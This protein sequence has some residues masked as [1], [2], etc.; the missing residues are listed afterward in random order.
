[1]SKTIFIPVF[2][3]FVSRNILNTGVLDEL[4]S[5][6]AKVV[7]FVPTP[8]IDFY[9]SEYE[10]ERVI[11][12]AFDT[13]KFIDKKERFFKNLAELLIDSNVIRFRMVKKY[14]NSRKLLSYLYHRSIIGLFGRSSLVKKL[15]R[16]MDLNLNGKDAFEKYFEQYKP[17]V[18]FAT[19][20]FGQGDVMLL[21]SALKRGVRSVGM[22][23]SWDNNTTK[24]LMRVVPNLLIVQNEIIKDE[25][26]K[27]QKVPASILHVVGIAHYDYYMEYKPIG[28]EEYF[29]KIGLNPS[30]RLV[31]FSPAGDKFISTDW[32]ICEILKRAYS[33]GKLP[34]DVV[35][36]VRVHPTNPVSFKD[37][38]PNEHFLI[39]NPGVKFE[40]MADKKK[41]LDKEGLY[42]LLN[43]LAH[44]DVVINVLSS[45]VI[46]AAVFDKPIITIGFEGWEKR[47]SFGNSVK[48]Y[49]MDENMA[50][51]LAIEGTPVV[52]SGRELIE[53]INIYLKHPE[54][55]RAG[56]AK[57][58]EKQCWKLDGKAKLR[59]AEIIMNNS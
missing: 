23:A 32:Q 47:V 19:D 24:G 25:S 39:E 12:E 34:D 17:D 49:H 46:D 48:R 44:V 8:K 30:K 55:D 5:R 56:R 1:M 29:H 36:L 16:R 45:I 41:E 43:T 26:M 18:I 58:V 20:V 52:K 37:F 7:L 22:V 35:I 50:K 51:L 33:E 4:L 13:D 9:K 27:I 14:Q 54:I 42:H 40:G 3:S 2:Q 59:I 53:Q 38:V 6:G 31:L 57:I 11:V 10:K 15:F 28:K 21:K